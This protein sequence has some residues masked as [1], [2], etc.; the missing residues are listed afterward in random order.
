MGPR[1]STLLTQTL[2]VAAG[3][4][5][6]HVLVPR[7]ESTT[8]PASDTG[9]SVGAPGALATPPSAAAPVAV[10]AE[11]LRRHVAALQSRLEA[12]ELRPIEI[13]RAAV[14]A[15]RVAA[16]RTAVRIVALEILAGKI[17]AGG[18]LRFRLSSGIPSVRPTEARTCLAAR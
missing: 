16:R 6:Y 8:G 1:A 15:S 3:I 9:P 13:A 5:G 2:L 7:A 14:V 18:P 11:E 10:T 12:I 4:G 17:L